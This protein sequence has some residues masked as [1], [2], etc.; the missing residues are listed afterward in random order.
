MA[1]FHPLA[2]ANEPRDVAGKVS[3]RRFSG[4]RGLEAL[5]HDW[6]QLSQSLPDCRFFYLH[7]W[8]RSY[9]DT[10]EPDPEAFHFFALY[11]ADELRAVL[12]LKAVS[13]RM[14]GIPLRFLEL[15]R[16]PH[17]DLCDVVCAQT[18]DN[19]DLLPTFISYL[20]RQTE[21][22]WDVLSFSRTLHN[23]A[24]AFAL[25]AARLPLSIS[26]PRGYS[27][28]VSCEAVGG[29]DRLVSGSF[30]RNLGRFERR[31]TDAGKL[32][33]RSYR[34]PEEISRAFPA[35]LDVESSGWKGAEHEGTAIVCHAEVREFYQRLPRECLPQGQ[36]VLHLLWLDDVCIAGQFGIYVDDV[37]YL[38]K[39]GYDERYAHL[40]PGNLLM[41]RVL[42]THIRE[43]ETKA[44]SF[45]TDPPWSRLWR[46][47]ADVV[48][49]HRVYRRAPRGL[50][51]YVAQRIAGAVISMLR[52]RRR[53]TEEQ[54][55]HGE[56]V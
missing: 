49:D 28:Y 14:H 3:I 2:L 10:L 8:Y 19:A 25:S 44:V 43:G 22:A 33:Y 38:L 55:E 45:V 34:T 21:L 41:A 17:L 6:V 20:H 40:A 4:K 16:H 48:I 37:L 35:F 46:P 56:A 50:V 13:R 24:I 18:A 31:A 29:L 26:V 23:S 30:R 1:N 39:I 51:G 12:P 11:K 27:R 53:R 54:K 7:G 36:C 9:L 42:D 47:Q 32:D 52:E 5:R 15:P